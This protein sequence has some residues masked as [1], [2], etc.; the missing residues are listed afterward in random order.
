MHTMAE[1]EQRCSLAQGCVTHCSRRSGNVQ[2]LEKCVLSG[3]EL[4]LVALGQTLGKKS[5]GV[6]KVVK[7][8][9]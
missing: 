2:N 6:F 7:S 1:L 4:Y 3:S 9:V 5:V 8:I